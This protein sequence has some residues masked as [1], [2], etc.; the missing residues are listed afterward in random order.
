L[1][2]S[3][4]NTGDEGKN[5]RARRTPAHEVY[6]VLIAWIANWP[7]EKIRTLVLDLHQQR[8]EDAVQLELEMEERRLSRRSTSPAGENN[9]D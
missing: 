8:Y 3:Q 9:E 7:P 6:K 1:I 5:T 4:V 2:P